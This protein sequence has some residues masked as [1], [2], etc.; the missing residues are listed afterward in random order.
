MHFELRESDKRQN[1]NGDFS[2]FC[3][4]L[5][6][7]PA[8]NLVSANARMFLHYDNGV[9]INERNI[10]ISRSLISHV[11]RWNIQARSGWLLD[12]RSFSYHIE[13]SNMINIQSHG[14]EAVAMAAYENAF[15]I[16]PSARSGEN[17]KR[18]IECLCFGIPQEDWAI[19]TMSPICNCLCCRVVCWHEMS[20]RVFQNNDY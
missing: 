2:S 15:V 11:Q 9:Y 6:L 7:T 19:S 4:L 8:R 14:C 3:S 1:G 13:N 5:M 17:R 10:S 16:V 20:P 12:C 18:M